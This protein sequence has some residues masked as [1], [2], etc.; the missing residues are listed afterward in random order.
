[1]N[2]KIWKRFEELENTIK[3]IETTKKIVHERTIRAHMFDTHETEEISRIDSSEI[4]TWCIQVKDLL[5]KIVNTDSIYYK[6]FYDITASINSNE[7]FDTFLIIKS[8][9]LTF[10]NDYEKG[11]L[12]SI[13]TLIQAEV[14]ETQLEQ[15]QELLNS[16]YKLASAVIAGVV[17]ETG[18]REICTQEEIA[19]GKLDKMNADLA[20]KG[21]YNKLEQKRITALADIRNS[22][23]HG[24]E[25]EFTKEDVQ[26]MIRDIKDFLAKHLDNI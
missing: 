9:F 5:K 19:H 3:S 6:E 2:K 8:I 12:S 23:A 16:G 22:A 1:M 24:K 10:K 13:K 14:F 21:I 7:K 26:K 15:A 18:I 17:L 25:S 11:Y 20:K 4:I